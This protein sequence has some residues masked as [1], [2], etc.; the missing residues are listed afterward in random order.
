MPA[1][2]TAF[3]E[4]V[5]E[6]THTGDTNFTTVATISSGS[7]VANDEYLIL[8]FLQLKG[9]NANGIF[10]VRVA[11]GATPSVIGIS[12]H[13]IEAP[14]ATEFTN[15]GTMLRYTVPA[16]PV[17]VVLQHKTANAA[18]TVT[19]DTILL[20]AISLADLTENTDYFWNEDDDSGAPTALTTSWVDFASTTFTPANASDDW[21]IIA[22][23]AVEIEDVTV[24]AEARIRRDGTVAS[25]TE[26]GQNIEFEGEDTQENRHF[27]LLHTASLTAA[28]H[29]YAISMQDGGSVGTQNDHF[30]SRIFCL[31]LNK[32]EDHGNVYTAARFSPSG[33]DTWETHDTHTFTPTQTGDFI[34]IGGAVLRSGS[35][36]RQAQNRMTIDT[37]EFPVGKGVVNTDTAHWDSGGRP[38]SNFFSVENL[39]N[40]SKDLDLDGISR[41]NTFDAWR[42]RVLVYFSAEL[43]TVASPRRII[44]VG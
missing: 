43:A 18:F 33:T 9:S 4:Q 22:S 37:V 19:S 36:N 8:A 2:A 34:I 21:L 17:D 29:T 38:V 14:L 10:H 13:L 24:T 42:E 28:E 3:T 25:P 11:D 39:S 12:E 20:L 31:N 5:T 26:I 30:L 7:L 27:L 16:T 23:G 40:S 15:Y 41:D 6:Q 1:I 32:F 44:R 35:T